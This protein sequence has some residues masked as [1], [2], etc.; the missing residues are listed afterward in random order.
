MIR[1][2][3]LALFGG[4]L[5]LTTVTAEPQR[6]VSL[7]LCTDAML[8]ELVEPHRIASLTY[9][10]HDPDYA[11]WHEQARAIPTNHGLI[12]D[13]LPLDPDLI[14]AGSFGARPT[15]QLLQRLG[16]RVVLFDPATGIEG[17]RADL[18]RL[19]ALL[20]T[21]ERAEHLVSKLDRRLAELA[22]PTTAERPLAMVYGANGFTAGRGSLIDDLLQHAGLRNLATD[23]GIGMTG[24]LSLEEVLLAAPEIL[25]VGEYRPE[26][27]ARAQQ[28]LR[29]RAL[30][31]LMAQP[32]RR[33]VTIPANRW[34][35]P[36]RHMLDALA[37][38]TRQRRQLFDPPT[39]A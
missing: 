24:R 5:M 25:I 27:P 3:L 35:C 22:P 36:G 31:A 33:L 34:N 2:R 1:L 26:E 37:L 32:G 23:L 13:I 6:I 21:E 15:V 38:L 28:L 18:R 11:A 30:R 20:G 10:S 29:H 16:Y 17:Y 12:E 9:L 4:L 14:L 7:N 8:L 39:D 19:A